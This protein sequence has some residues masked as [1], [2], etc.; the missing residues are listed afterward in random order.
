[1]EPPAIEPDLFAY[2]AYAGAVAAAVRRFKYQKRPD[3]AGP[4]GRLLRETCK[5]EN[6]HA[7]LV[8]PVPLHFER[9]VERGYNQSALLAAHVAREIRAPL[10]ARALARI[11]ATRPQAELHRDA[12][13]RNLQGVFAVRREKSVAGHK[14][15]LVDDVATTGATLGGCRL[16][17]L[18]AGARQV[19][20]LVVAR[21]VR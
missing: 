15:L 8:V 9:L 2:A 4:L 11:V 13:L 6:L 16:A 19:I 1:V 14:V 3:L 10:A 12:R 5:R 21:A 7:D 18:E 17:L 20:A